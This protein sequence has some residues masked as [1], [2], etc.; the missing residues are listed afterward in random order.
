MSEITIRP[1]ESVDVVKWNGFSLEAKKLAETIVIS[2]PES[3]ANAVDVLKRIK[4]FYKDVED[5]RKDKKN[6]FAEMVKRID[7]AFKPITDTLLLAEGQIKAKVSTYLYECEKKRQKE[8]VERQKAYEAQKADASEENIFGAG[9]QVQAP[10][11]ILPKEQAKGTI[12]TASQK[13]V[14]RWKVTDET[15]VPREYLILDEV[16]LNKVV[17]A[18]LRTIPG[19]E[20]YEDKTISIR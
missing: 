5:A 18:G 4:V 10:A 9:Q 17:K 2:D 15:K 13:S 6:P 19:F 7:T 8:E 14:W 3:Q 20:I 12:A 11:M 1:D 16:K